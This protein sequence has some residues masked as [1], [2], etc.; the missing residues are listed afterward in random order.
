MLPLGRFGF[1]GK[2]L[3]ASLD[4]LRAGPVGR[5][6]IIPTE[7]VLVA[8]LKY[9]GRRKGGALRDG[10]LLSIEPRLASGGGSASAPSPPALSAGR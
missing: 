3:W 6:G 5:A 9:F 1:A 8:V 2:G 4:Q 7:P 10:G